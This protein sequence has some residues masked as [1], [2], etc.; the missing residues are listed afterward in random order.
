M[1]KLICIV[2]ETASGKDTVARHLQEKYG[3]KPVCSYTTR[4]PR[5]GET[6]G[7]EHYFV[8]QEEFDEICEREK[9]CAYTKIESTNAGIPGYEYCAILTD[10]QA[11]D[12]Y[13]IDP[14][15]IKYLN[16]NFPELELFVIYIQASKEARKQRALKRDPRGEKAFEERY[17]NEHG[18]FADFVE[19]GDWTYL[20]DNESMT[21][22]QLKELTDEIIAKAHLQLE[23]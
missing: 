17:A 18:M 10:V 23:L 12:I 6:H 11:A 21:V 9:I 1:K 22:E 13:V 8:S 4:P 14:N 3:Y 16:D 20:I 19:S 2:G 5:N 15:G 7:K